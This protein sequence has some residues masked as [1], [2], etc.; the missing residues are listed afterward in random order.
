MDFSL[1][2]TNKWICI[3][4]EGGVLVMRNVAQEGAVLMPDNSHSH[5]QATLLSL[6]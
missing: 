5:L 1:F 2:L 4:L 3:L 6:W